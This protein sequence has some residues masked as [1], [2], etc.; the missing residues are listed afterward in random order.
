MKTKILI[1][2]SLFFISSN[3][4]EA[5]QKNCRVLA[6]S[7]VGTYVGK[8]KKGLA[9]GKGIAKGK[10]TYEGMFKKGWPNG[11]GKLTFANG[12]YF[13][14]SF[15]NGQLN[16]KGKL[17]FKVNGV[18]SVKV[19]YWEDNKYVGKKKIPA[20]NVTFSRSVDRYSFRRITDNDN[21]ATNKIKIK[22]IQNGGANTTVSD[23]RM[24]AV[25]GNRI[26]TPNYV[27]FEN[28]T[29]PFKCKIN[30]TT[31]NK[32][33]TMSYDCIIEFV[34]NKPGEWELILNN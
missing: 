31:R 1:I 25:N 15:K 30:Y 3:L 4:I 23:I 10:N 29:F 32:L 7:L 2:V 27:G 9:N 13:E 26:E 5:Q 34:I 24:N 20:Y 11:K 21:I 6:K 22:F 18:D 16:G 19:G 12:N 33:K 28:I 14:G 17:V 8:C